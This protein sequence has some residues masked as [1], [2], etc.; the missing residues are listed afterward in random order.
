[1]VGDISLAGAQMRVHAVSL[2]FN[3]NVCWCQMVGLFPPH[4]HTRCAAR[5]SY[6]LSRQVCHAGEGF[7]IK[8]RKA[9]E[10]LRRALESDRQDPSRQNKGCV[11][12]TLLHLLL[13]S[14]A[15]SSPPLA[16]S[17]SA[18]SYFGWFQSLVRKQKKPAD[19]PEIPFV[20]LSGVTFKSSKPYL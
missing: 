12:G 2:W 3:S 16:S 4:T 17:S 1:M 14:S 20:G 6:L 11:E 18:A 5:M 15:S 9:D 19:R 13:P 10:S 8:W 7:T